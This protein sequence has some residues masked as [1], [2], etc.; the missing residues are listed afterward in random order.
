MNK[1]SKSNIQYPILL[2]LTRKVDKN[3]HLA[4]FAYNWVKKI[5]EKADKLYVITWQ[6]SKKDD[7]PENVE[8]ISLPENKIR[9]ILVIQKYLWKTVSESDG[10]FAHM[11]PEYTI[12]AW[13]YAKIFKKKIVTWYTHG[14]VSLKLKLVNFLTDKILTA[15]KESCRLKNRKKIEVVG[16]GIDVEY[17]KPEYNTNIRMNANATNEMNPQSAIS[18]L[19]RQ[20]SIVSIGRI[21]PAKN[22]KILIETA[23]ILIN[24]ENYKNLKVQ[25]IGAP[26]LKSQESYFQELKE[27]VKEK[28]LQNN[29][30]FLGAVPHNKILPYYRNADLFINLS[31][32]GSVDKAVLEAMACETLVLTS[33]EA[34][35]EIL[36]DDRLFAKNKYPLELVCKIK[37][38]VNLDKK[39]KKAIYQELR[40]IVEN[41]YSLDKLTD[42]IIL[43][44]KQSN[45]NL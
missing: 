19:N 20:I 18:A 21:S 45:S 6:K 22:Y 5:G 40:K 42:K 41:N 1:Y 39:Q 17:F 15:S 12:L 33:N 32:T 23:D 29:I 3:D 11:N 25:I 2:M 4:G 13:P 9:K 37:Y 16:H 31:E 26:G 36:N 34:F 38:L 35:R 44:F 28:Q 24:K 30:K 43:S 14:S 10:V 8:I 7:L 27:L